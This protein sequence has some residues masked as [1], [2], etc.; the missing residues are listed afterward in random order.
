MSKIVLRDTLDETQIERYQEIAL[1]ALVGTATAGTPEEACAVSIGEETTADMEDDARPEVSAPA[2]EQ[3]LQTA[4]Q[5]AEKILIQAREQAEV[6]RQEAMQRGHAQGFEEGQAQAKEELL[7]ALVAFA[8][9]GQSLLVLEEQLVTHLTP[10]LVRLGLSIAEKIVGQHV[11]AEPALVASV[12]ERAR[13]EL[14]HARRI[15]IWLHPEDRQWLTELRPDLV[16]VGTVGERSVEVCEAAEIARGGC[17][18][19]TEMG[20]VDATLP[21][22][23]QEIGRQLLDEDTQEA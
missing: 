10:E 21:V 22:Q 19:E 1:H 14:P 18:V 7:P 4:Q 16:S 12:L 13:A 2:L 23:L 3:V 20:V 17:R 11:E 15:R 8:Q 5:E 6:A 9:A